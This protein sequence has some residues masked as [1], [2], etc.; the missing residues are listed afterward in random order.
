MENFDRN[1]EQVKK[2][3]VYLLHLDKPRIVIVTASIVGIIVAS[4]LL[5]M[6]Y[7]K[8]ESSRIDKDNQINNSFQDETS[9]IDNDIDFST[10]P[11]ELKKDD[12]I[13]VIDPDIEE[14]KINVIEKKEKN[15]IFTSDNINEIVP[16]AKIE[17]EIN[18]VKPKTVFKKETKKEIKIVSKKSKKPVT[19]KKVAKVKIAKKKKRISKIVP[20]SISKVERE[21]PLNIRK[22]QYSIQVASYDRKS[23]AKKEITTLKSMKYDAYI[24]KS[25]VNGKN[26]YRVRIGPISSK[27]EAIGLLEDVQDN[28]RYEE[29]YMIR[30]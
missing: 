6:N 29:S 19:V 28:R 11:K 7:L 14:Q 16:A 10:S 13:S 18:K 15:E 24:A 30:R 8:D 1:N 26:Y 22:G 5:G 21:K 9:I 27:K 2:K 20:V 12:K 17:K 3:N 25:K 23:K 4:F